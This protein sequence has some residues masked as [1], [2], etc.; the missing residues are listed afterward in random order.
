MKKLLNDLS[1][2]VT[3][4]FRDPSF[5]KVFRT[6]IIP[7]LRDKP[8]IRIWHA[9]CS[10]GEEAYSMAILLYEEGLYNKTRIYATDMNEQILEKAN[11]GEIP[12]TNMQLFTRNYQQAG[13][14]K[15]FSRYYSVDDNVAVIQ[16]FLKKNIV[17]AHHNLVTDFSFNEF[18]VILCRNVLIYFN[19]KLKNRVYHLLY[20]SLSDEGFVCFGSKETITDSEATTF[21]QIIHSREKIYYKGKKHFSIKEEGNRI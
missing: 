8:V 20:N 10:S 15:E 2:N 13:G 5:F 18:H 6:E 11:G 1:I 9:G 14:V 4:M 19:N 12:I 3:E 16:P 17:F 7:I 21:F